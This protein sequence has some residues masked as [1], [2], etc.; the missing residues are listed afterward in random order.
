MVGA[1]MLRYVIRRALLMAPLLVG[2]SLLIFVVGRLAPGDP[3]EIMMG[4][5]TDPA[6]LAKVRQELGLDR[7]LPE[8]YVTFAAQAAQLEFGKSYVYRGRSVGTLV[9]EAC[10]ISMA[11][12]ALA[13]LV[14]LAVGV[15]LGIV[16]A[17]TR[18]SALD[19]LARLF[20]LAGVSVPTFVLAAL[21]ILVLALEWGL[22]PVAGWGNPA[23]YVMPVIV[24]AA[25][26]A[27]YMCRM[28]RTSMLSALAQDYIRTARG[29]GLSEVAV[30]LRHAFKNAAINVATVVGLAF[31]FA[32]TGS[33]VVETI[34]NIPG[35]GRTAVSAVLQ[36]DY[37]VIQATALLFTAAFMFV[38][39][40]VDLTYAALNPRIR[41]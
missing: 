8:Q 6:V 35:I 9:R 40:L 30:L 2:A 14:A 31:G 24:L 7:P 34:Y 16:S 33:F 20:A 10:L 12:G 5:T 41:Y 23:N 17:V 25:R 11:I 37:P 22:V 4:E 13:T 29:K 36:R 1:S 27:A 26:P 39:L 21:L 38:N 3:A 15:P 18:G 19:R 32:I 28:T